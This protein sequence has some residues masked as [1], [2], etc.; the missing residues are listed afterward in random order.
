MNFGRKEFNK[1]GKKYTFE[2]DKGIFVI[3][4][5]HIVNTANIKLD[6]IS[7][8]NIPINIKSY[9]AG[10]YAVLFLY[11]TGDIEFLYNPKGYSKIRDISLEFYE[12]ITKNYEKI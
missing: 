9:S 1:E 10:R 7:D 4:H 8:F 3:T 12:F 11:K 5:K 6:R 2:Y